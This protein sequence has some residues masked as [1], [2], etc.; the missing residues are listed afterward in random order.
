M[1][2]YLRSTLYSADLRERFNPQFHSRDLDDGDSSSAE[3]VEHY[4]QS[5]V[6]DSSLHSTPAHLDRLRQQGDAAMDAALDELNPR[7]R[8][9]VLAQLREA[10]AGGAAAN[11]YRDL[12]LEPAWLDWDLLAAGQQVYLRY[13]PAASLTLFNM[14]LVGGFSA[15]KITK[16]LERSGYLVGNPA[17]VMRRL[18]DTGRLLVDCCA[19]GPDAMRPGGTGWCA[20][21]RVR[22]L[23]A[24]VRR[25]LLRLG[26]TCSKGGGGSSGGGGGLC[27][28]G[29]DGPADGGCSGGGGDSCPGETSASTAAAAATPVGGAWDVVAYGVPINQE[30]MAAT[31]LAFSYNVLVGIEAIRAAPLP[32]SE[33]AAYLHLWRYMGRLLGVDDEH[34]PCSGG[35]PRAKAALES[36]VVHLLHPDGL[37]VRVAH[38]LLRAPYAASN[39]RGDAAYEQAGFV[40]S[41]Q[42]TRLLVGDELGDALQLPFELRAREAARRT[43]RWVRLYSYVCETPL[44]GAALVACHRYALRLMQLCKGE[45]LFPMLCPQLK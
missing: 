35:P 6:W 19:D 7:P 17:S 36:I 30:D 43:L 3:L 26:S 28:F 42:L 27:P 39:R 10:P 12:M 40:R 14:S 45:E 33:Q 5:F 29:F 20:A 34:N 9:D 41:A 24:K 31:L 15:P 21:I 16:V 23:H 13:L 18:L 44:L 11:L 37:S 1:P 22:A 38:H 25:R 8:D 32:R 2:H 4:G